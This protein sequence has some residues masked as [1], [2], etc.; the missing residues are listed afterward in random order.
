MVSS[1]RLRTNQHLRVEKT[2]VAL[3]NLTAKHNENK[4]QHSGDE[5]N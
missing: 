1:E 5:Y 4:S 3:T 2:C